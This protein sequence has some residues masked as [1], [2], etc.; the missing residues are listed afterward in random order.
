MAFLKQNRL[1]RM[2]NTKKHVL[3]RR[4]I[5]RLLTQNTGQSAQNMPV[6]PID[7]AAVKRILICRPNHRLG[8]MLLITPLVEE[9]AARFPNARI[10]LFVKGGIAVVIFKHFTVIDR[11]I[12]LPKKTFRYFFKY[13]AGWLR[14]KKN[15][16][17]LVI[18]AIP[19]SSSGKIATKTARTDHPFF[20]DPELAQNQLPD[21]FKQVA[22]SPVYALR[23]YL[24]LAGMSIDMNQPVPLMDLKL[25]REELQHGKN[26]LSEL[27]GNHKKTISIFT[28]ATGAKCFSKGW[29]IPFYNALKNTYPDYNIVEILPVENVSQIDFKAPSFYSKD[30]REIGAFM[31]ATAIFI[32]ADS[33]MMHL[34]SASLVPTVGL[35]SV[36]DA[37]AYGPYGNGSA[38]V[39]IE[40]EE[41]GNCLKTVGEILNNG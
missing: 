19:Y 5:M 36:T 35:F 26:I 22:K 24:Q 17:D 23:S 1:I 13:V 28:F 18:N 38:A 37:M 7:P 2:G 11:I 39:K 34:A 10:D 31:A 25:S 27:V 16:Y 32:G 15:R 30:L 20:G 33:G 40:G 12:I 9:T 41:F 3:L 14:L 4:W 8:N 6:K 29:W 21:D